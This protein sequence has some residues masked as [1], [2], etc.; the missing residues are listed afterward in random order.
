MKQ[1]IVR[2]LSVVFLKCILLNFF[3][4]VSISKA[5]AENIKCTELTQKIYLN[6]SLNTIQRSVDIS[7][8]NLELKWLVEVYLNHVNSVLKNSSFIE[9]TWKN[10]TDSF[11]RGN[12]VRDTLYVN[13]ACLK[14]KIDATKEYLNSLDLNAFVCSN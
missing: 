2:Y 14:A 12:C 1:N 11:A 3:L 9:N 13:Q 6:Q 8:T 4:M 7:D 5:N 10:V